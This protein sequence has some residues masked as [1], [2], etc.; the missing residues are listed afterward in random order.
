MKEEL[1][2]KFVRRLKYF[3]IILMDK[4]EIVVAA[5][6]KMKPYKRIFLLLLQN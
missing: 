6:N 1:R 5:I 2:V 4:K 3:L